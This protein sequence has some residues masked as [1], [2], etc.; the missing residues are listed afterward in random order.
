MSHSSGIFYVAAAVSG[1]YVNF[2]NE[3]RT[4]S[5]SGSNVNWFLPSGQKVS[6]RNPKYQV[7][8]GTDSQSL[9]LIQKVGPSDIGPYKC[10]SDGKEEIL[11]L[12]LFCEFFLS[13]S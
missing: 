8:N 5:C 11:E 13:I 6:N 1:E 3:D 4:F 2:V 7:T 10:A 12:K 9:L